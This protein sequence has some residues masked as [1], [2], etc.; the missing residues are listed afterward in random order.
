VDARRVAVVGAGLAGLSTAVE[1]HERGYH[2]EV[3]ER[4]RLLGGRATSFEIGGHEVDNGQHVFLHCCTEF[5]DFVNRVGMRSALHEQERFDALVLS[6]SGAGSRLRAANLPA[7]FHLLLSFAGYRHLDTLDKLRVVR[8]I[9]SA[10]LAAAKPA[11][12]SSSTTFETWLDVNGQ[13]ARTRRAFWDPFF[14]PAVNAPFDRVSASDGLFVLTTA[15]LGDAAGA[16]FG[17]TTVPLARVAAAAAQRVGSVRLSTAVVGMEA[18]ATGVLLHLSDDRSERF[19]GVVFAV[20]PRTAAKLLAAPAR[21][22]VEG[23][24][25][26]DPY[27]IVDVH[28]WH[29]AGSI[30]F[31]FA[32]ALDSP[33]QWIFEKQPGYLC[34]SISAASDFLTMPTSQLQELA[35]NELRAF[36]PVLGNATLLRAG[37]TRNPEATY[38]PQPGTAR[39]PQ[40]TSHPR[41]ALAGS[42]TDT[43]WP[44]TMESAVRSGFAAASI[45]TENMEGFR[46]EQSTVPVIP[47]L[48]REAPLHRGSGPIR[49]CELP[50][51]SVEALPSTGSG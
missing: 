24:E 23:L 1:L 10:A 22:G 45:L 8:A 34:C 2:V 11:T 35:W 21:F 36:V 12:L 18:D 14:V 3:F 39:V 13:N 44:D 7:P 5:I 46:R 33:L 15:F 40:R 26:Y 28:L 17:W 32:A 42:W 4:T 29:N 41:V 50:I 31:D 30:G 47:S 20:P 49:G 48:S 19:D 27:P 38:L 25:K 16:R 37:A 6:R 9:V 51:E 43:G